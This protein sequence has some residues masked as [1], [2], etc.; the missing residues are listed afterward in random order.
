[1][2]TRH[3]CENPEQTMALGEKLAKEC[4]PG[5]VIAFE[6]SLG[7]G[8]TTFSKGLAKGLGIKQEVTSPT[9][10]IIAVY[11]GKLPLY[12]MDFYRM[13]SSEEIELL[14]AEDYFYADGICLIEWSEKA[15]DL[16]PEKHWTVQIKILDND[17][18]EISIRKT[19][20]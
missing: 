20:E 16:L 3:I 14:G 18:R 13:E 8:K 10:T 6:G 11:Q 2:E 4:L 17:K 7:A 12:H 19:D 9:Y 5:T 15:A 1:M